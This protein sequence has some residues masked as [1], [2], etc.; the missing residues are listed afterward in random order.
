[1]TGKLFPGLITVVFLLFISCEREGVFQKPHHIHWDYENP[2]WQDEGFS[3]CAGLV[4]S[5]IDINTG[6]TIPA[7]LGEVQ[8]NYM[9]FEMH[10]LDNGHTVQVNCKSPLSITLDG[11]SFNLKQFHYH[12]HSEHKVDGASKPMELHFVH[13]NP[14][15]NTLTVLGVFVEGGGANNATLQAVLDKLPAEEDVET[16]TG[17]NIDASAVMPAN[18]AY[19]TYSGSLTTPPCSMGLQWIVFKNPIQ[20]SDAQI[21]AFEDIHHENFRPV[22]PL[23]NRRVL[24]KI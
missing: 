11:V 15:D 13:Q 3:D 12:T 20:V 18:L 10:I 2:D 4:Q 1:M 6:K 16:A 8:F 19:Y 22:Q 24:E 21:S 7:M 9:P 23:N 17:V 5:P 14:G